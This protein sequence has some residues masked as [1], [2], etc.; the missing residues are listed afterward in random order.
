[1]YVFP[2]LTGSALAAHFETDDVKGEADRERRFERNR[3]SVLS[4]A[5]DYIHHRKSAGDILDVGCATGYFLA[6]F[7]SGRDWRTWGVDFSPGFAEKAAEKGVRV[8]CGDISQAQFGGQTFDAITVLDA[9]YYFQNP[10]SK[11]DELRSRL[12]P[13]GLLLLDLPLAG[14]R[15]WRGT[16]LLGRLLSGSR[17]SLLQTSDHLFYYEP[18]SIARLLQQC[19]FAVQSIRPL[20]GNRHA[21]RLRN[22]LSQ[23]FSR[24]SVVLD[25]VS[26]SRIFLG[27]RFLVAAVKSAERANRMSEKTPS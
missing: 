21:G 26:G 27:P 20:P 18:K 19:G 1:V 12:K 13:D 23:C 17:L 24:L 2:Q 15:I 25:A 11:L 7:F 5:A 22:A 8:Y 14:S 6:R 4:R 9:F 10:K 16:S 3:E